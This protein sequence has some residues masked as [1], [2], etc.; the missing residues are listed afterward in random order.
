EDRHSQQNGGYRTE[1]LIWQVVKEADAEWREVVIPGNLAIVGTV[2][3]D[4][5]T[6]SFSRKVLDRAFTMELSEIDP[7]RW[8]PGG[9]RR[10]AVSTWPVDSWNPIKIQLDELIDPTDAQVAEINRAISALQAV[11]RLLAPAQL[12]VAYRTRDE[13]AFYL[14]HAQ[15]IS[16]AFVDHEG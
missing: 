15:Q 4:E 14:L 7:T 2:N 9:T 5:S 12:Q 3:M 13:V 11:N 10:R 1:P 8:R 16:A 6:H